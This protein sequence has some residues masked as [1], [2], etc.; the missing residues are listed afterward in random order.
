MRA[1]EQVASDRIASGSWV[2]DAEATAPRLLD[3][4]LAGEALTVP[5]A[6]AAV[7]ELAAAAPESKVRVQSVA[8]QANT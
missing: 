4:R 2:L 8:P 3:T 1:A 7:A 6:T 5:A